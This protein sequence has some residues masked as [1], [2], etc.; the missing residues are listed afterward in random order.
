M[1]VGVGGGSVMSSSAVCPVGERTSVDVGGSEEDTLPSHPV[2][3]TEVQSHSIPVHNVTP[4]PQDQTVD[5]P[6][7][8]PEQGA[9]RSEGEA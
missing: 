9:E 3:T 4:D 6:M 8:L 7:I 5:N 2:F 1:I